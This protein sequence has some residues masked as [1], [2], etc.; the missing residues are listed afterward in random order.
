MKD[1]KWNISACAKV[2]LTLEKGGKQHELWV[3]VNCER[4]TAD[5]H[6]LLLTMHIGDAVVRVM[7][8]IGNDGQVRALGGTIKREGSTTNAEEYDL[9]G[10]NWLTC[11]ANLVTFAQRVAQLIADCF[12]RAASES[13]G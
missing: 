9:L 2:A 10:S 12:E 1:E 11:A 13:S 6:G 4:L 7:G 8:C 3:T 5:L